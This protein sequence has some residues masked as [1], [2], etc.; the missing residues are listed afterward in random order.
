MRF[1]ASDLV[2]I[3]GSPLAWRWTDERHAKFHA[4]DLA[5]IRPL[6]N[7]TATAAWQRISAPRFDVTEQFE[8]PPL[9]ADD[10]VAAVGA[11]LESHTGPPSGDLL[12]VWDA[13][14]AALVN[15]GLFAR[16]WDDFWYPS[17]DDLDVVPIDWSWTIRIHH[18]GHLERLV[19]R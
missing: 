6:S 11:W 19:P 5:A 2:A 10:Y 7:K 13:Q 16:H 18:Y 4:A 8:G 15:A 12:L 17:S 14:T 9:D 1:D 3:E